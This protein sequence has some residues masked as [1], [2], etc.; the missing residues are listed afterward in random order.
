[1]RRHSEELQIGNMHPG[2][3]SG[4]S[5]PI[6]LL[7][8]SPFGQTA[9]S[10]VTGC[11]CF[12]RDSG[13]F[14]RTGSRQL[15]SVL[16][17]GPCQV[18]TPSLTLCCVEPRRRRRHGV[19]TIWRSPSPALS[20]A[21]APDTARGAAAPGRQPRPHWR[22]RRGAAGGGVPRGCEGLAVSNR[23]CL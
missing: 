22:V 16:I 3:Y 19:Y 12:R 17:T 1:M 23:V 8:T 9:A 21:A 20:R 6:C 13:F 10:V 4:R 7:F 5:S 2:L 11:Q 14:P 15:Y 18:M